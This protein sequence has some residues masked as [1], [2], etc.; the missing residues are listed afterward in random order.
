MKARLAALPAT[1]LA[2]SLAACSGG[3]SLPSLATGSVS[4]SPAPGAPAAAAPA[5][6][7]ASAIKN[8]PTQRA[9]QVGSTS[10]RA[11]KC[12]FNFDPVRLKQQF[13]AAEAAQ[14]TA[15][16]DIGKVEK[17]YDVSFNGISRGIAP[18]EEYCTEAKTKDIKADLT[19]HLA[20]DYAPKAQKQVAAKDEGGFFS[21]LFDGGD[22]VEN[23]PK[24]GTDDWWEKQKERAGR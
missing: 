5:A 15:V 17:I 20:G 1:V 22:E 12:G 13:L 11:V 6:A 3:P 23:G 10:A 8:D 4:G 24:I 16:A 18:Q 14:G 19:R 2:L 9:F 21:V 7:E